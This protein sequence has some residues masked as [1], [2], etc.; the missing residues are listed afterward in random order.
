[1]EI[2]KSLIMDESG[3]G[4]AEYA[5]IIGLVAVVV[6]VALVAMRGGIESIFNDITNALED[7]GNVTAS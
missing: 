2:I 1:M 4:M 6:M 3:Q 7:P 5:L